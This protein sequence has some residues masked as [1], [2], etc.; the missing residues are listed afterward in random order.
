MKLISFKQIAIT[1]VI[2]YFISAF[3][4]AELNPFNLT[5]EARFCQI[6]LI[7]FSLM[8]QLVIKN[9]T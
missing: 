4:N 2:S 7:F 5:T 3:I 6:V 9:N 8:I 1:I